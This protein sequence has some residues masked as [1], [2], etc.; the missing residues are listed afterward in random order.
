MP[1]HKRG[2]QEQHGCA[3]AK[4]RSGRGA[5]PARGEK[6]ARNSALGTSTPALT[7]RSRSAGARQCSEPCPPA[8]TPD[9]SSRVVGFRFWRGAEARI[10]RASTVEVLRERGGR[11]LEQEQQQWAR[12]GQAGQWRSAGSGNTGQAGQGRGAGSDYSPGGVDLLRAKAQVGDSHAARLVR[13]V[14]EIGLRDGC[15]Q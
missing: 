13:I 1:A 7:L 10:R 3:Q 14:R 2:R 11:A 4:M 5:G 15:A 8:C 6:G 12:T 9:E